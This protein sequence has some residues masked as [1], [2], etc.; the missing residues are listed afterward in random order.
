MHNKPVQVSARIADSAN[1]R[2]P[3]RPRGIDSADTTSTAARLQ[4]GQVRPGSPEA[5]LPSAGNRR[6]PT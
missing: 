3:S 1:R 6:T 4:T 5:A 2:W